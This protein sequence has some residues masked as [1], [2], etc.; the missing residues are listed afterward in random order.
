MT[1][2]DCEGLGQHGSLYC[3]RCSGT[4]EVSQQVLDRIKVG[5]MLRDDRVRRG[6]RLRDEAKAVGMTPRQLSDLENGK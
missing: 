4:G 3:Q 6:V 1:C 2:P 5:E